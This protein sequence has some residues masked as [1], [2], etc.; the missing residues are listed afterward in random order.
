MNPSLV[1]V[2]YA[3]AALAVSPLGFELFHTKYRFAEIVP[4]ALA[5]ALLSLVPTV[6]GPASYVATVAILRFA[7]WGREVATVAYR[8][9]GA[10]LISGQASRKLACTKQRSAMQSA[11]SDRFGG[12]TTC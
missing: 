7:S 8:L 4:A 5:G 11:A 10:G 2:T 1:A 9:R 12:E 6:G 3:L